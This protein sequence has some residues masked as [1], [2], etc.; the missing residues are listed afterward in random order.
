M[1]NNNNNAQHHR[2]SEHGPWHGKMWTS[3]IA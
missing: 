2:G 3:L 1:L